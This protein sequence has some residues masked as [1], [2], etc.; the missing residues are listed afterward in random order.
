[1]DRVKLKKKID[2]IFVDIGIKYELIDLNDDDLNYSINVDGSRILDGL[3]FLDV[4]IYFKTDNPRCTL[5]CGNIRKFGNDERQLANKIAN[6]INSKLRIGKVH[7]LEDPMQ[8]IYEN[9]L[10]LLDFTEISTSIIEKMISSLQIA[11][12]LIYSEIKGYTNEK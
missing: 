2:S 3:G 7:I 12:A 8:L 5:I 10:K 11:I 4:L 1:M 6:S 9:S